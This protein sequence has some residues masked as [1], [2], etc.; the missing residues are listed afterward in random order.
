VN[1]PPKPR[2]K[3]YGV[4]I[5]RPCG[6]V[7]LNIPTKNWTEEHAAIM[8]DIEKHLVLLFKVGE[9]AGTP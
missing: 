6:R 5:T 9:R 3:N 4:E 2:F 1:R 7:R 8:R